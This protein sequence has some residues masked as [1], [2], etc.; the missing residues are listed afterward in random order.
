MPLSRLAARSIESALW[1]G[2]PRGCASAS[3]QPGRHRDP[4]RFGDAANAEPPEQVGP[5]TFDGS[6]AELKLPGYGLV[7]IAARDA[8]EDLLLPSRQRIDQTGHL[9]VP[10][11][12]AMAA[13]RS[14]I[15]E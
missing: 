11:D 8:G 13:R 15:G 12:L 6:D 2:K 3:V 7:Q 1:A 9:P 4:D 10:R 5:I 14:Q